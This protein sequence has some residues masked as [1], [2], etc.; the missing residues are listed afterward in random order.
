MQ[1]LKPE[2]VDAYIADSAAEARPILT[3]L[4]DITKE[5]GG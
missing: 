3:E 4:R 5:D 2:N 1:M